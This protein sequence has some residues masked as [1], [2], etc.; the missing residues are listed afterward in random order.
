[1]TV[2][3]LKALV[4][5]DSVLAP[6]HYAIIFSQYLTGKEVQTPFVM[7]RSE[8]TA[9]IDERLVRGPVG[10]MVPGDFATFNPFQSFAGQYRDRAVV[11]PGIGAHVAAAS[12]FT[13]M[14]PCS[15]CAS[16][17]S[18]RSSIFSRVLWAVP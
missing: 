13:S 10:I 1:M 7:E 18:M 2:A 3:G 8:L 12:I 16:T 5:C 17:R 11:I 14:E 15:T 4:L 9:W 6:D